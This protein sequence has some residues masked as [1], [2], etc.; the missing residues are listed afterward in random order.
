MA[1][2]P[3]DKNEL[4]PPHLAVA[5][6]ILPLFRS[7]EA[8]ERDR[9]R[10]LFEAETGRS[11]ASGTW[12]MRRAYDA[13]EL[14]QTLFLLEADCPLLAGSS[15]EV[16]AKLQAFADRMPVQS[17]RSEDQVALQQFSTPLAL[18]Y[19]AGV[20]AQI[21]PQD[22]VL[23]PSAGNGLFAWSAARACG[24]LIL[25]ELDP[26]RRASLAEAFPR[27]ALSGHDAE[28]I[29]DLLCPSLRPSLVLMN[30][31]FARSG[32]RGEDRYA[33]ARHLGAALARLAPGGRLVGIMPESFSESGSGRELRA[34]TDGQAS[35]RLDLLV[36]PGAFARHGTGVAVRMVVY[37]K[38]EDDVP[39]I[40]GRLES[41]DRLLT[42]LEALPACG[43]PGPQPQQRH[44]AAPS[45]FSRAP[46]P[47]R[48]P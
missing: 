47:L 21:R 43:S 29:D 28:L 3:L 18:A 42:E 4:Q 33:G 15:R 34:R 10:R 36:P 6:A 46:R 16:L 8:V 39:A 32:G 1:T 9:L 48:G 25:N 22:L 11:D 41:L 17:Y 45:L 40:R 13:L 7:G 44:W 37:D 24:R 12:T 38:L 19:L 27:A 35:L 31:P 14:A 5:H 26:G 2:L 30:P 23:E 20:A